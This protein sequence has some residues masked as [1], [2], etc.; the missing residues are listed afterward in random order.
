MYNILPAST[1]LIW[2]PDD[3][4]KMIPEG[5]CMIVIIN[6]LYRIIEEWNS[7]SL[8]STQTRVAM[9]VSCCGVW[10]VWYWEWQEMGIW[11]SGTSREKWAT[12][13]THPGAEKN[14]L[15][16]SIHPQIEW[17]ASSQSPIYNTCNNAIIDHP[18][19]IF[20]ISNALVNCLM[21]VQYLLAA[22]AI[23]QKARILH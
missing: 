13:N 5:K 17:I 22:G 21:H 9:T 23:P 18:G 11:E 6:K 2:N 4:I 20:I 15:S 1:Y 16:E 10:R 8:R 14:E 3:L 7:K 19:S 12:F